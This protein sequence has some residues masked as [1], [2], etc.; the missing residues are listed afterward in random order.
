MLQNKY[1]FPTCPADFV[2]VVTI[3]QCLFA[4]SVVMQYH[5]SVLTGLPQHQAHSLS[6]TVGR[7]KWCLVTLI[8][9]TSLW[10]SPE[11]D[12]GVVTDPL[13]YKSLELGL[14][15][16]LTTLDMPYA[17]KAHLIT[18]RQTAKNKESWHF[19]QPL[20]Q[21]GGGNLATQVTPGLPFP[22][23]QIT[24]IMGNASVAALFL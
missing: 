19:Q 6:S 8:K 24:Y 1:E 16:N 15:V 4:S 20:E 2:H 21:L 5:T 12:P 3:V 18:G 13:W 14:E 10:T 9:C 11:W 7:L 22:N 23:M 17:S